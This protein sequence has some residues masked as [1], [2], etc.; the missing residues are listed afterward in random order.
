M[1]NKHFPVRQAFASLGRHSE[2]IVQ[3]ATEAELR[4]QNVDPL[5]FLYLNYVPTESRLNSY[6][7]LFHILRRPVP[8]SGRQATKGL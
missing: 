3:F 2:A 6:V 1:P 7:F 5:V 4:P 8:K